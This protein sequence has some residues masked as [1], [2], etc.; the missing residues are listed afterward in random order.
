[1]GQYATDLLKEIKS[2]LN[3]PATPQP[4]IERLWLTL[5]DALITDF[6]LDFAKL[7]GA[8]SP[9]V[10]PIEVN[11][12]LN[13]SLREELPEDLRTPEND[14]LLSNLMGQASIHVQELAREFTKN[15]DPIAALASV[16]LAE[17]QAAR[18]KDD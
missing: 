12:W 13:F 11:S 1:L 8:L 9:F 14:S 15:P 5:R 2:A 16:E 4:G 7:N 10:V 3:I 6:A 18:T 17:Q